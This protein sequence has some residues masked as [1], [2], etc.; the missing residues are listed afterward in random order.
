MIP[1][2]STAASI[3]TLAMLSVAASASAGAFHLEP[4]IVD[5]SVLGN[6][7]AQAGDAPAEPAKPQAAES[8]K[9]AFGSADTLDF[10]FTLGPAFDL[11]ETTL[12]VVDAGVHW[13][14]AD[15]VSFGAFVEGLVIDAE[16]DDSWGFGAG[17]VAR[18]HFVREEKYSIFLE[19]G[20]GF[21]GFSDEVPSGGTNYDFT[22]RAALG[23]TYELGDGAR[24]VGKVGWFHIS[25]GQ[26]GPNNPGLDS[27]SVAIGLS[28][29][30]G[31]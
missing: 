27:V 9:R 3:A 26:T 29:P 21:A 11:E 28:F 23:M 1:P 12:G 20:A 31:R 30:L 7:A 4:T 10:E 2:R 15:G 19:G 8:E 14:V 24:L 25:N 5:P 16:N 6:L 18:W 17:V 22:P 13:F